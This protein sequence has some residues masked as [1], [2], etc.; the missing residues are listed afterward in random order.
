MCFFRSFLFPLS[1]LYGT[2]IFF[3]NLF[4]DIGIFSSKTYNYPTIGVGNLSVGGTG[5]SVAVNY[6]I[7]CFKNEYQL[8]TLSRGYGRKSKGF[9]IA[10]STSSANEVGDEPKMFKAAHPK[11][12]VAVCNRRVEGMRRLLIDNEDQ[13]NPLYIWD[14]C[15]QH[16]WVKPQSMIL[17]TTYKRPYFD[18]LLLPVGHLRE[19]TRGAKR[20]DIVLVTKCPYE[21]SDKDKKR[22]ENQLKLKPKQKLFFSTV[23]YSNQIRSTQ[24]T[25]S[26]VTLNKVSFLVVTGIADATPFIKF[27]NEKFFTFDYIGFNDHHR[28]SMAD[29]KRIKK[30]SDGR[31]ILTTEK[32]FARLDA[33]MDSDL[34]FYLPIE[35]CIMDDRESE[36]KAAIT[37]NFNEN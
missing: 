31:M 24:R 19:P 25:L 33:L 22:V 6:L 7:N 23:Q 11:V 5:K 32:D 36:F 29:I 4:F 27:L 10:T 20:A 3:R 21:I 17:L 1:F 2:I 18:D 15:F 13:K 30:K 12:K 8:T 9:Q 14:D 28:F 26:L 34:L 16:R 35:M 37:V